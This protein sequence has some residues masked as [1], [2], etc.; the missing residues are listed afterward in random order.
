M[1]EEETSKG[2]RALERIDGERRWG[3][4]VGLERGKRERVKERKGD[5]RRGI[6][7]C[8]RERGKYR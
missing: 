7:R 2:E 3:K 8:E 1:K 5:G 6:V 4:G